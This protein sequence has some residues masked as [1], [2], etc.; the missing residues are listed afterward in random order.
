M[1]QTQ[2]NQF[3][4]KTFEINAGLA[5]KLKGINP[6]EVGSVGIDPKTN[7]LEVTFVN[8]EVLEQAKQAKTT[9]RTKF[10]GGWAYLRG[11]VRDGG[12]TLTG[13]PK[14]FYAKNPEAVQQVIGALSEA[15]GANFHELYLAF[16]KQQYEFCLGNGVNWRT[17]DARTATLT[18]RTILAALDGNL[19]ALNSENVET[20]FQTGKPNWK[21]VQGIQEE[22]NYIGGSARPVLTFA[23]GRIQ[24]I[25]LLNQMHDGRLE[26]TAMTPYGVAGISQ[27]FGTIYGRHD[28]A[29]AV[30]NHT[31]EYAD[32]SVFPTSML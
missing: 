30:T 14:G 3:E 10:N 8:P 20:F 31:E 17:F 28:L 7:R 6:G 26:A 13:I 27:M 5:T 24:P 15:F 16:P 4:I 29:A 23:S 32:V 19:C 18:D 11:I 25:T 12:M 22:V 2:Q 9:V 1:T 21:N